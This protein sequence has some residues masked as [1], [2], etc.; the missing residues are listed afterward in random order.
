MTD[1]PPAVLT[2]VQAAFIERYLGV[3][4]TP[5]N[6]P[7]A[8]LA[9]QAESARQA[10]LA[11]PNGARLV[12][13]M[14][15]ALAAGDTATVQ[16]I[17]TVTQAVPDPGSARLLPTW[18]DARR[19]VGEQISKLETALRAADWP[20]TNRIAEFGL[21]AFTGR[22]LT[23]LEVALREFDGAQ[24]DAVTT[25]AETLRSALTDIET[26]AN[27][28]EVLEMLDDNPFGAPLTLRDTLLGATRDLRSGVDAR[29]AAAA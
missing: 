12:A 22:R 10:I 19:Q 24:G 5:G 29:L 27:N 15:K 9:K 28:D 11:M 14:D 6:D 25:T 13:H 2:P 26:F 20:L 8:A 7:V 4:A 3:K 23:Q 18:V 16:K 17:L 1:D 21:A